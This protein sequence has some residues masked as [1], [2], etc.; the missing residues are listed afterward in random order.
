MRRSIVVLSGLFLAV[1]TVPAGA[2]VQDAAQ[3]KCAAAADLNADAVA[4]AQAGL[5]NSCFRDA[6]KGSLGDPAAALACFNADGRG[7]V[8]MKG[9]VSIGKELKSCASGSLPSF[10]VPDLGGPYAPP[11][12]AGDFD[13]GLHE[14]YAEITNATGVK[15]EKTL[16][17]DVFG[18]PIDDAVL[19]GA[20]NS[21]GAKCQAA[22]TK[23]LLKCERTKRKEYNKCEKASLKNGLASESLLESTCLMTA[24]D[25]G[26]GQPDAKGLIDK[27]CEAKLSSTLTKSCFGQ[28]LDAVF[29]GECTGSGTGLASCLVERIDCRLCQQLNAMNGL[30]RDCDLF[31]DGSANDSCRDALPVCGDDVLDLPSE[32]CDDGNTDNGDCCSSSCQFETTAAACEQPRVVIQ[33]PDNGIFTLAGS[34][35]VTGYVENVN[36]NNATLTVNGAPVAI[37]PNKTFSTT[38]ALSQANIFNPILATLTRTNDGEKVQDRVVV[39]A[40][41]SITEGDPSPN[42]IGMRFN[43]SG[44]NSIEPAVEDLVD[45]DPAELIPPNTLVIDDDCY[46]EIFGACIGRVDVRISGTPPPSIG[47]FSIDMDSQTNFVAGDIT[48]NNLYVRANVQSVSGISFSCTI[49][50]T[51]NVVNIFGDYGLSPLVSAPTQIDVDQIGSNDVVLGGFNDTTNCSGFLGGVVEL[52]IDLFIGDIQDLFEP[53]LED[54]L[55]AEDGNGN[56]PI[57]GAIETALAGIEIAGPIG[58]GLGVVLDTPMNAVLED[59]VGI[60]FRIDASATASTP[61]PEAPDLLA[62]YDVAETFPTFGANTPGGLPY[63]LGITLST[64]SFNQLLRAQI[65]SGLLRSEL[66]AI[67]L[68]TGPIPLTAGL[69]A[70]FFP[71]LAIVPPATPLAVRLAPTIA[72]VLTSA[73]GPLGEIAE[74]K[75][76]QLRADVVADPNTSEELVLATIAVD[77]RLGFDMAFGS[78]AISLTITPPGPADLIIALVENPLSIDEAAVQSLLP[79]ILGPLLPSLADALGSIPLP[80]FFGLQLQGVEVSR[81]SGG[82]M[83]IFANLAPPP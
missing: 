81:I 29:P 54:F 66:T 17:I 27:Q 20:V 71:E 59:P 38:V 80:Q 78:G 31:D 3:Q 12:A 5:I 58:D 65:E 76:A 72:P 60:T 23:Q 28:N 39:I 33:I 79:A 82:H 13:A 15:T 53:A 47:G 36:L 70:A 8:A 69:L 50:I 49:D 10:G 14:I 42:G 68:G 11:A 37:Q 32:Q 64:S 74:L 16:L 46:Q 30:S 61:D 44:L 24:G 75:L 55:N 67:D 77:A 52:L 4:W 9:A 56:T 19:V 2:Q 41:P 48:L 26:T 34:T 57:A 7:K 63:G 22:V 6:A 51:S 73:A 83:G 18:N 62:S 43:D 40:G 45:I 1:A 25:P 35:A 21:I